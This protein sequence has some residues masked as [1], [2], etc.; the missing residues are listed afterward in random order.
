[1]KKIVLPV[2]LSFVFSSFAFATDVESGKEATIDDSAVKRLVLDDDY[3]TLIQ[4]RTMEV[5]Q[6]QYI[7]SKIDSLLPLFMNV[8]HF[9]KEEKKDFD[10]IEFFDFNCYHCR[11]ATIE[12]SKKIKGMNDVSLNFFPLLTEAADPTV[13]YAAFG[14]S[15]VEEKDKGT[16]LV[17][18]FDLLNRNT[19]T[20]DDIKK[21]LVNYGIIAEENDVNKFIESQAEISN[22]VY[23]DMRM[24]GTP[25]FIVLSNKAENKSV[26]VILGNQGIQYLDLYKQK[27]KN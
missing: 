26:E 2:L 9:A 21:E 13:K 3:L 1:M 19:I 10:I 17:K 20:V 24:L 23:L 5:E 12:M 22:K 6:K 15:K 8:N 7:N 16:Y 25:T 11:D 14:L 4:T 18:M 27:F